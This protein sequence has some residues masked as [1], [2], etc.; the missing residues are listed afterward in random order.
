MP[1]IQLSQG[2]I[3]SLASKLDEFAAVLTDKEKAL[4]QAVF[5]L[6]GTALGEASG[7]AEAGGTQMRGIATFSNAK[8]AMPTKLP[9]MSDAFRGSFMPG[10]VGRFDIGGAGQLATIAVGGTTVTWSA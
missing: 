3:D 6:A 1:D 5:G 9:N 2:D 8:I 10:K 7:E 4:L